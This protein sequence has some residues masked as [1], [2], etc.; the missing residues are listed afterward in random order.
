M[1]HAGAVLGPLLTVL[2]LGLLL[3]SPRLSSMLTALRWTFALS[4][5][6]GL[7]A[8]LV[9]VLFVREK[10][11]GSADSASSAERF[12]MRG[13]DRDFLRYVLVLLVFTLG[14]SSDAFLLFRVKEAIQASGLASRLAAHFRPAGFILDRFADPELRRQAM[15]ALLL[16]LVWAFFHAAKV[17]VSTHLAALSDRVGRKTMICIGWGIY[18]G[19]YVGFSFLDRVEASLQVPVILALFA[20]YSLYFGATEGTEK[21]FVTDL[22]PAHR[23]GEAFGLYHALTGLGALPA[24]ILFGVVYSALGERGGQ[25]AFLYGAALAFAAMILL[26]VLVRE[27]PRG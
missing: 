2:A 17:L 7:L 3:R 25:V 12:P 13:L 19:V 9:L 4:L 6:P 22:V 1:D 23:R 16:P 27:K 26:V 10:Q 14:N 5:A 21:A 18:A 8:V 20:I 24:S 11:A 15:D